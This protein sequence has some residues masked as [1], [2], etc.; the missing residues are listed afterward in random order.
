MT[1]ALRSSRGF[2]GLDMF[3]H[4]SPFL[5]ILVFCSPLFCMLPHLRCPQGCDRCWAV[6]LPGSR[7]VRLMH[8]LAP[9]EGGSPRRRFHYL[10][11]AWSWLWSFMSVV[12][13]L[14]LMQQHG[15]SRSR[16]ATRRASVRVYIL[17]MTS[18]DDV[19]SIKTIPSR[20]VN[21][22]LRLCVLSGSRWQK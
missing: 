3:F 5:A 2:H 9:I 15:G 20:A 11:N 19:T 22:Q 1:C 4:S 8:A 13:R 18:T 14:T 16:A 7:S 12:R 6:L 17:Q 21:N 10:D